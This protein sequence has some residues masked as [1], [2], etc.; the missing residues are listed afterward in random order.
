MFSGASLGPKNGEYMGKTVKGRLLT[1]TESSKNSSS[2]SNIHQKEARLTEIVTRDYIC[3]VAF[4]VDGKH[5][6]GGSKE[7]K[8]RPWRVE[9][10]KEVGTPMDAE[11]AVCSVAVSR[12]GKWVVGGTSGGLVTV[13]NAESHL[14]VTGFK[15]HKKQLCT[16]DISPDGTK[17]ATGSEDKTFCVWSLW[18]GKRLL[19]FGKHNDWVVTVKFSPD[20]QLI[21]IA[22]RVTSVRIYDSQNGRLLVVFPIKVSSAS[23]HSLAWTSDNKQL[24]V[25]SRDGNIHCLDS[26]VFTAGIST[27][28][29]WPT[30]NSK[31]AQCIALERNGTFVAASTLS[32]VSFWDTTTHKKCGRVVHH[33][34]SISSIA[35]SSNYDLVTAG[36]N[37]ITVRDLRDVLPPP[38]CDDVSA[39]ASNVSA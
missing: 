17:I 35:I 9:D 6:V 28:S 4:L 3:S 24:F 11:S 21:A 29:Q 36:G 33:P 30:N 34:G 32:S 8:I 5:V 37:L 18:T 20:G 39:F 1:A 2:S 14:K 38:Y 27:H 15:A 25:L 31:D 26:D 10:G 13:W 23:N 7:G 12:D 16:V 22:T 19:D